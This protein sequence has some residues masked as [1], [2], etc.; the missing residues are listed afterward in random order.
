MAGCVA[1]SPDPLTRAALSVRHREMLMEGGASAGGSGGLHR[2][3]AQPLPQSTGQETELGNVGFC[4]LA[5]RSEP[6][7]L[8]RAP[9]GP[10]G[11]G[12]LELSLQ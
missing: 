7:H 5:S 4:S 11:M 1:A 6:G 10:G 3:E 9:P 8:E 2:S 12:V